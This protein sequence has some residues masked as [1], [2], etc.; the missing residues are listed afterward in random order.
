MRF[1]LITLIFLRMIP[2]SFSQTIHSV[3]SIRNMIRERNIRSMDEFISELPSDILTHYTLMHES[4]SLHGSSFIEPRAILFGSNG[5]WIVSFNG[6]STQGAGDM[7]EMMLYN[8]T[9]KSYGF[10]ELD[11]T[12]SAPVLKENPTKCLACHGSNPRPIWDHYNRWPGAYGDVDDRY[13]QDEYKY[14]QAFIAT[15]P[16]HP[17]Y[18]HL[19]NLKEGYKLSSPSLRNG[20]TERTMVNRNRDFNLVLYKQ[21]MKDVAF[22][23]ST[24]PKFNELKAL[25]LY[26]LAKCY[27]DPKVN[28][29]GDGT[30]LTQPDAG[31]SAILKS[32]SLG[33]HPNLSSPFM[34]DQFLDYV[35]TRLGVDT[36][37]WYLNSRDIPTYKSLKDGSDRQHETWT[38]YV[39]EHAPEYKDFFK[40]EQ[41]SFQVVTLALSTLKDQKSCEEW[42][43]QAGQAVKLLGQPLPPVNTPEMTMRGERV[44]RGIPR[45]CETIYRS[46]PQICL[47]CHTQVQ[48][49]EK[50][51]L[52]FHDFPEMVSRGETSLPTKTLEHIKN[53]T[54]PMRA[55]GD[56]EM[57]KKY[58][59]H[60][61]PKLKKYLEDLLNKA[62]PQ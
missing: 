31:A 54:M 27:K 5:Q 57:F 17:R 41:V 56:S 14:L 36:N 21:K 48:G 39:L 55:S 23:M 3:E 24:H 59:D 34:P 62:S 18:K 37:S 10:H 19:K 50:L 7:V 9:E 33:K 40:T 6:S 30:D 44:C 2:L 29:Q 15:T 45:K 1:L 46:V 16:S 53:R 43:P 58:I 47:K 38:S 4:K 52:P 20:M 26:F 61:Y 60:D 35:F 32:L 25:L 11:F 8:P 22:E 12:G 28:Y 49:N 51:Y 13:T 42:L